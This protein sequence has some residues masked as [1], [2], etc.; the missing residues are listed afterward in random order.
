HTIMQRQ[1]VDDIIHG[2]GLSESV[3]LPTGADDDRGPTT[4]QRM[5]YYEQDAAP[6]ALRAARQALGRSGLAPGTINHLVTI[7]CTG[8]QAPGVDYELIHGLGLP[9]T[10]ERTHV[11]FMG[12]HAALNGLRVAR[13]YPGA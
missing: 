7:S 9:P 13:A 12:C 11:G 5:H 1:V 3:F 4:G 6:L 2:T 8:F 10:T